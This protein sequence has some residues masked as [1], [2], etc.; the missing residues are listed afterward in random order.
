M[1]LICPLTGRTYKLEHEHSVV[2]SVLAP[3]SAGHVRPDF[4]TVLTGI[5]QPLQQQALYRSF[6]YGPLTNGYD[7]QEKV[8]RIR[9][10]YVQIRKLESRP[11]MVAAT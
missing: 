9:G 5:K 11:I 4:V 2:Q 6:R 10:N 3:K 8:Q 7:F 1:N